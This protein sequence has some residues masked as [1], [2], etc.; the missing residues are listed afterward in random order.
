MKWPRNSRYDVTTPDSSNP[1][2]LPE[3]KQGQ[4][5]FPQLSLS[6]PF[7]PTLGAS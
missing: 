5:I 4:G 7:L 1:I 3:A 6:L 2:Q